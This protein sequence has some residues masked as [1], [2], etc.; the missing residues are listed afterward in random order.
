MNVA[1]AIT[2][3]P[4]S[5]TGAAFAWKGGK[6]IFTMQAQGFGQGA[7]LQM[8]AADGQ[9]WLAVPSLTGDA[10][11]DATLTNNG[12]CLVECAPGQHR[13]YLLGNFTNAYLSVLGVP[14]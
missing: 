12:T 10:V 13:F 14:E 6:Y 8:L 3:G 5:A 7:T 4:L 2:H 9:N 11:G 1:A